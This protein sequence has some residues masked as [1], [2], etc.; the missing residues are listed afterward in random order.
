[1][2][3][4]VRDWASLTHPGRRAAAQAGKWRGASDAENEDHLK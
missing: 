2:V 1:M 3:A 4:G